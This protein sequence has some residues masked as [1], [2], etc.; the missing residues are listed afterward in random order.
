MG[1]DYRAEC[2]LGVPINVTDFIDVR[3][4]ERV[5]CPHPE[6]DGA[7]FCPTCGVKA[8][9]R[10]RTEKREFPKTAVKDIEPF[11]TECDEDGN[12]EGW[13]LQWLFEA[14][15]Y[16]EGLGGLDIKAE[17][18]GRNKWAFYLVTPI[19]RT[20]SSRSGG[21]MAQTPAAR[22]ATLSNIFSIALA[23]LGIQQQIQL[24]CNLDI[25]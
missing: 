20:G 13:F 17:E 25:S 15:G 1:I 14:R 12:E 21:G 4:I 6:G 5:Y 19:M 16:G 9:D 2:F 11:S 22:I 3:E 7:K 8:A 10:K 23:K 18:V 24:Y